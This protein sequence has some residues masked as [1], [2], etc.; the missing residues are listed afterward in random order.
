[1]KV[2]LIVG[3]FCPLHLG[4][5]YLIDQASMS[6]DKLLILPYSNP[7]L[8]F[9][10][11]MRQKWLRNAAP[12]ASII[13][14]QSE[15]IPLNDDSEEKHREFC[16]RN[17]KRWC[18]SNSTD[19]PSVV[20]TSEDY[21]D[22]FAKYLTNYFDTQ[23]THSL[24][25]INRSIVNISA[26]TI[27][28]IFNENVG[29]KTSIKNSDFQYLNE[30]LS[31]DVLFDCLTR[32]IALYG[33]ESSGKTTLAKHFEDTLYVP[34]VMEYGREH[35]EL[36]NQKLEYFDFKYIMHRQF[37]NERKTA[38]RMIS[39]FFSK[40]KVHSWMVCDTTPLT[41]LW[42]LHNSNVDAYDFHIDA[43]FFYTA[44][45]NFICCPNI[46]FEQ[47][48]TRQDEEFRM[49]GHEWY[50]SFFDFCDLHT[51]LINGSVEERANQ[52]IERLH[53]K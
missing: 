1:M 41:T 48:G 31:K 45:K 15:L 30:F 32:K 18:D 6:V 26:T 5:L 25:D 20:F 33:G 38:D 49:K 3:K 24:V 46:P 43:S 27:R 11:L 16:A 19:Y 50:M 42:Y 14:V 23:V 47:D 4:H 13:D 35:Y 10:L 39:D 12:F 28:N 36:K 37:D 44:Y 22:G 53:M 2:G 34:A 7:D 52:I 8:G 9:S 40:K 21:G 51:I 29:M 17:V